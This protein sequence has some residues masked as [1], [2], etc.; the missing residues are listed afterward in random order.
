[1][2][3]DPAQGIVLNRSYGVFEDIAKQD[4]FLSLKFDISQVKILTC[5]IF[6]RRRPS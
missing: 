5:Q 6:S 3:A 4:T 2:Y 1:M